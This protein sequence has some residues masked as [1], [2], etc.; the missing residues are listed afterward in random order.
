M[1]RPAHQEYHKMPGE[2]L[3]MDD[4]LD[5]E[6]DAIIPPQP[7]AGASVTPVTTQKEDAAGQRSNSKQIPWPVSTEEVSDHEGNPVPS[8]SAR[9]TRQNDKT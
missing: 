5:G 8:K 1:Q 9:Q 3:E 4:M 7:R 2:E 6:K